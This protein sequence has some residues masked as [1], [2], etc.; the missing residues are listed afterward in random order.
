MIDRVELIKYDDDI[1][2]GI[3]DMW[4]NSIENWNGESHKTTEQAIINNEGNSD[5]LDLT[6]ARI[7]N[8]VVGYCKLSIDTK[9]SNTLYINKL[10]VRDGYQGQKIGKKLVKNAIQKSLDLGWPR[11]DLNTWSGNIMAVPLYKKSGFF[12][13]KR[14]DETHLI[15]LI[16]LVLKT[17]LFKEY[18]KNVDWY[19]DSTREIK[20]EPDG[21][22]DYLFNTWEYRWDKNGNKLYIEFTRRGRGIRRIETNDYI[23]E[24]AVED[25]NLVFGKS[26]EIKYRVVNKSGKNLSINLEGINDKNLVYN[27]EKKIEVKNILEITGEF[28][29]REIEVE[30]ED[31][32]THPCVVTNLLVNNKA[33]TLKTGVVPKFPLKIDLINSDVLK[34]CYRDYNNL[35]YLNME[36]NY[37]VDTSFEIHFPSNKNIK[38]K[39]SKISVEIK[40]NEKLSIPIEIE[41][42]KSCFYVEDLEIR[43][44]HGKLETYRFKKELS[45]LFNLGFGTYSGESQKVI[46]VGLG[47]YFISICKKYNN[48]ITLG[49]YFNSKNNQILKQ[50]S[51]DSLLSNGGNNLSHTSYSFSKED[52]YIELKLNYISKSFSGIFYSRYIRLYQN[53]ISQRWFEVTNKSYIGSEELFISDDIKIDKNP[54]T[55]SYKNKIISLTQDNNYS[56]DKWDN[57]KFTENWIFIKAIDVNLGISWSDKHNFKIVNGSLKF[58]SN[59]GSIGI[60][61]ALKTEYVVTACNTFN[62][63]NKFRNYIFKNRAED[64]VLVENFDID[65]KSRNPFTKL[66]SATDNDDVGL[67]FEL[68]DSKIK[69]ERCGSQL[70]V[71]NGVIEYRS[72]DTFAPSIFS[73]KYMGDE[74]LDSNYPEV[75]PKSWWN[76]WFGGLVAFPGNFSM[77]TILEENWDQSFTN[78]EDNRGNKWSG[79]K[80]TIKVEKHIEKRG[81]EYTQYY[82]TLPGVPVIMFFCEFKSIGEFSN[83]T[84]VY[85]NF[86]KAKNRI[87]DYSVKYKS[88]IGR[89]MLFYSGLEGVD[90]ETKQTL[91]L[92]D[93]RR[94]VHLVNYVNCDDSKGY[95]MNKDITM[96]W[97]A[98]SAKAISGE[99]GRT[100]PNFMIFSNI[101][102]DN[103]M[104]K[105]FKELKIL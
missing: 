104:L 46:I 74:W 105:D 91:N 33:V 10:N 98:N 48:R 96:I 84:F 56:L 81:F 64:R 13:V 70:T 80:I 71:N 72:S 16:P 95:Y 62:K 31:Y 32:L 101:E 6:L 11:I 34:G 90:G 17:D 68:S 54:M 97:L 57:N 15:N 60:G 59:L 94:E 27:F 38:F 29:V 40:G 55:F 30:Q 63:W 5:H 99:T 66:S 67:F 9:E 92:H 103:N 50:S 69:T 44:F 85:N 8:I 86:F 87:T 93:S 65:I 82:L 42:I 28:F 20:M 75:G 61:E 79:I 41:V 37:S 76:P 49:D 52:G 2:A 25:L 89:D 47:N 1:A 3:K 100:K 18:F 51:L 24:S 19:E 43:V 39:E 53:G 22:V 35:Y 36:N 88:N 83:P 78:I 7:D 21:D 26:Y 45:Q 12:W 23:I 102:I 14:D 77:K 58:I 4:D 73:L